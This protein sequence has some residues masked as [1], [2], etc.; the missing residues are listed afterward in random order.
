MLSNELRKKL[1]GVSK[2]SVKGDHK[3]RNLFKIM[4]NNFEIWDLAHSNIASNK[5]ATTKGI[6]DVTVDGHSG[7][8]SIEIMNQLR[9]GS[10]RVKPVRR[11]YIPKPNGKQRPL[12][13]P[14]YHDKLVQEVCRILLEAVFEPTFSSNSYGFRPSKSCHDALTTIHK[15]WTGT[16]WFIEFD[17]K[18]YFDN[19]NCLLYTSDAA[20]E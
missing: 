17:I 7:E 11:V 16:K 6:D 3:V 8:R 12:G 10:Y 13:L 14:A 15:T 9:N 19:I 2:C 5:G 20:D 18:G 1:D 4:V